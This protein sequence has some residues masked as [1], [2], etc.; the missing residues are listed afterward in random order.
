MV[1]ESSPLLPR[2]QKQ[3]RVASV[4]VS[5]YVRRLPPKSV[6]IKSGSV[7]CNAPQHRSLLSRVGTISF[8]ALLS[9]GVAGYM[10]GVWQCGWTGYGHL[11]GITKFAYG[12]STSSTKAGASKDSKS[13]AAAEGSN[14]CSCGGVFGIIVLLGIGAFAAFRSCHREGWGRENSTVTRK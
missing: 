3:T 9:L 8:F 7:R 2:S 12:K 14:L 1:S 6:Y 5:R 10:L 4:D 13:Q 11:F